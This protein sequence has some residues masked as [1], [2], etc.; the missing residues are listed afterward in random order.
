VAGESHIAD[1]DLFELYDLEAER[2][3]AFFSSG[4]DWTKA[5]RCEGWR[6]RELLSHCAGVETY[7]LA[8]LDDAIGAL[9]EEAGKDGVTGVDSFNDWIVTKRA[10]QSTDEVFDEWRTKNLE[11]RRRMRDLGRDGSMSSS[12]GPYNVG[13]MAAHIASEYATHADDMDVEIPD[14]DQAGRAAWRRKV[15]LFA[16]E[17]AGKPVTVEARGEDLIVRSADKE[18]VLHETDFVEAVTARLPADH[19]L[20]SELRDALRALA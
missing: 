8:C 13:L 3:A 6:V 18:A 11:V 16:V 1:L 14:A 5:T 9:F 10:E 19:P 2:V 17:E 20:D 7:H 12:V 15:S 4:P